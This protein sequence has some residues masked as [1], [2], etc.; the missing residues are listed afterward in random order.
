[1]QSLVTLLKGLHRLPLRV[2]LDEALLLD[3][4]SI[5]AEGGVEGH[6]GKRVLG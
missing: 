2:I 3:G 6:T 1:M 4:M 5:G